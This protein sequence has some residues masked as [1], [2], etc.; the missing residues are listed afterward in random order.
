MWNSSP[1]LSDLILSLVPVRGLREL[2]TGAS[3]ASD[4]GLRVV[5]V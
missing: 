5:S 2:A 4:Y 1:G 3:L